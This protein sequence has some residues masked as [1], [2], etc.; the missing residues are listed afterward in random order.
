MEKEQIEKLIREMEPQIT[1]EMKERVIK[2]VSK[3]MEYQ[4]T[5]AV[6]REVSKFIEENLGPVVREQLLSDKD[7][8]IQ[9]AK[10]AS[11][12]AGKSLEAAMMKAFEEKVANSYYRDSMIK[13]LF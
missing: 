10:S 12:R 11:A 6:A 9:V 5:Q 4:L 2:A 3:D 7:G 13:A 1:A 8:L